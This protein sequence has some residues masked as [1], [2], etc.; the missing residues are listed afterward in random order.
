MIDLEF[1]TNTRKAARH[2]R[3]QDATDYKRIA[4]HVVQFTKKSQFF[5]IET[6]SEKLAQSILK[7]FKIPEV[8][9][10]VSKPGAIRGSK[11]VGVEIVRKRKR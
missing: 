8:T 2:D 6:L 5:L 11:N 1:S 3:I 10:K 7:K 4:K 9:L